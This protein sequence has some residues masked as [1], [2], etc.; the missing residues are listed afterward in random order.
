MSDDYTIPGLMRRVS[1]VE[2][3]DSG[4]QQRLRATGLAGEEFVNVVRAQHFGLTSVPPKGAEGLLLAQGGRSD[5][6]HILGLEHGDHRRR[7]VE[8]GGTVL[9]DANGQAISL[10]RNALRI[11]GSGTITIKANKVVIDAEVHLGGAD[12]DKPASMLGTIDSAG[13]SEQSNLATK[14]FVK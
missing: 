3:D 5:R 13:H 11:V 6:A 1:L 14:V 8:V 9:Y 10:V 2:L 4:S 12:A 7:D